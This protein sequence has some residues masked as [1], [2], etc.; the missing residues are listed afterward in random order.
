MKNLVL[1]AFI[2]LLMA[3]GCQFQKIVKSPDWKVRYEAAMAYYQ[4]KDYYRASL[5][6]EDLVPLI[7]GTEQAENIQFYFPYCQLNQKQYL[8]ASHYFKSFYDAYRYSGRA[9]EALYMHAFTLYLDAPYGYLDQTS[10]YDAIDAMQDFLNRYPTSTYAE[11]ANKVLADLRE[12]QESKSFQ[13][14]YLYYK[15]G[16]HKSAVIAFENFQKDF[17]DAVEKNRAAYYQAKSQLL[18]AQNSMLNVQ[19]ER[20][21][22][23]VT[24]C[25]F[26]L[27]KNPNGKFIK[28]MEGVYADALKGLEKVKKMQLEIEKLKQNS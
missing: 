16:R 9:E 13:N 20:Y 24:Y 3:S 21:E 11:R 5:L 14:A 2:V 18:Y 6:L 10:A 7:K 1:A 17:P 19:K 4:K 27:D 25:Q 28:E 22:L 8:L 23:V 15:L 12:R 26:F